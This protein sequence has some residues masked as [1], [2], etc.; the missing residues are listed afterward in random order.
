M[1]NTKTDTGAYYL[2]FMSFVIALTGFALAGFAYLKSTR[3]EFLAQVSVGM[4]RKDVEA[5]IGP[6]DRVSLDV[7]KLDPPHVS[8]F[9]PDQP[10]FARCSVYIT[11][12]G[13]F[14]YVF[15][16]EHDRVTAVYACQS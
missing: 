9:T 16:D 12:T 13:L 6:P 5:R 11:M 3:Y 2:A 15:F 14:V 8:G 1:S 10:E 4:S 7:R